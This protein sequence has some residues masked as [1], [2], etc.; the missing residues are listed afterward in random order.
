MGGD[1]DV[2]RLGHGGDLL[3]FGQAAAVPDIG[4]EHGARP[5]LQQRAELEPGDQALPRGHGAGLLARHLRDGLDVLGQARLLDEQGRVRGDGPS[6]L[7]PHRRS[8]AAV[9]VEH[10]VHLVTDFSPQRRHEPLDELHRLGTVEVAGA[11]DAHRLDGRKAL[12]DGGPGVRGD[13]LRGERIVDRGGAASAQVVVQPHPVAYGPAEELVH[14]HPAHLAGDVPQR[15]VD[16]ACGAHRD[17]PAAEEPLP[18][19]HLPEVL[20]AE[21]ILADEKRPEILEAPGHRAGLPLC[22]ALPPSHDAR[23]GLHLGEDPIAHVRADDDGSHS[24]DLH[25]A[26]PANDPSGLS[27][28]SALRSRI[29]W[30]N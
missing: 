14:R 24:G 8:G 28:I 25:R 11:G 7:D 27:P 2:V 26:G 22:R 12:L 20:D 19:R 23:V 6:V 9:K 1:G 29:D 13:L 17:D 16:A 5:L 21:R 15:L 18:A 4:L 10:D 3:E 30:R